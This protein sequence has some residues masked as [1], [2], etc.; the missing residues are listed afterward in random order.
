MADE[1]V[2]G[3]SNGVLMPKLGFGCAFGNWADK[4]LPI[5]FQPEL[6]WSALPIALRTGYRLLDCALIYATHNIVSISLGQELASGRLQRA[7]IFITSKVFHPQVP[8]GHNKLENTI[9][10]AYYLNHPEVDIKP[11]II[12][13]AERCLAELNL[14]YLDLLLVHWPGQFDTSDEVNGQRLRR[15]VWLAF[16]ELYTSGKV[17]A[18]GVSNFLVKHLDALL[19]DVSCTV[20]P[21]V[22]QIEV[23]PYL[24]QKDVVDYCKRKNIVVQAWGAFGS[25]ATGV[26]SDPLIISL[27]S[28]YKKNTGQIILRWLLQKGLTALPKSSSEAR[29]QSNLDIFD[30]ILDDVD[31]ETLDGLNRNI[32]SVVTAESIA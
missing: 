12:R 11:R 1:K 3:L 20:P 27:A 23:S 7:D 30:F 10:I 4:S 13:D 28:K 32:S 21:M 22:N 16:Q 29:M 8:L 24:L 6:A 15:E 17:R 9:D 25:G 18:I 2:I 5:G 19:N 26:L 14:G 31:I